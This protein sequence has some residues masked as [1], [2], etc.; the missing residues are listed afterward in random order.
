MASNAAST[1]LQNKKSALIIFQA[2]AK[3]ELFILWARGNHLH[4]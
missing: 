3:M 1:T 4:Y 2:L